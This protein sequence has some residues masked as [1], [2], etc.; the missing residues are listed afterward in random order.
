[1]FVQLQ[2]D[3]EARRAIDFDE[4]HLYIRLL[5]LKYLID[6]TSSLCHKMESRLEISPLFAYLP[7][8]I[9]R[10]IVAFTGATYKKRNGKYMGQI[11]K[12]DPRNDLLLKIP[13]KNDYLVSNPNCKYFT[14]WVNLTSIDERGNMRLTVQLTVFG[15]TYTND[16]VFGNRETIDYTCRMWDWKGNTRFENY[17]Y[18]PNNNKCDDMI[19]KIQSEIVEIKKRILMRKKEI[20]LLRNICIMT[21]MYTAG[22]IVQYV[23]NPL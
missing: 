8:G 21:S 7:N 4:R 23:R 19:E 11:P 17:E 3:Q 9:I 1:M 5:K 12:T 16:P 18:Y 13:K 10:E 14:S 6:M 2:F 22:L 15:V 20:N